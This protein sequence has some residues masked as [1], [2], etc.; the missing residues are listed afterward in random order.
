MTFGSFMYFPCGVK[1]RFAASTF[2]IHVYTHTYV[3]IC[4][5]IYTYIYIYVYIYIYIYIYIHIYIY[6]IYI[7]I[8]ITYIYTLISP[9]VVRNSKYRRF[10][11]ISTHLRSAKFFL[12]R[13]LPDEVF[14][15]LFFI[16][17]FIFAVAPS[18]LRGAQRS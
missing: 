18:S 6:M 3:Y 7:Y 15:G 4:I 14:R 5:Y 12:W 13:H 10:E 8:Y 2:S 16:F 1:F 17:L 9:D 11:W